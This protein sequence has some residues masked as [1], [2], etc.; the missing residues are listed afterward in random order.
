MGQKTTY[1]HIRVAPAE[2]T[3]IEQ[4]AKNEGLD[5]ISAYLLLL[6]RRNKK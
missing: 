4:A 6:H 3:E 1:I 5:S 2:K